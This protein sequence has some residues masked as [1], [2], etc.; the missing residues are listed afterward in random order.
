MA[1]VA[2]D[3][4]DPRWDPYFDKLEQREETIRDRAWAKL[5]RQIRWIYGFLV[6]FTVIVAFVFG[7][8]IDQ[9]ASRLDDQAAIR[10]EGRQQINEANRKLCVE[11]EKVKTQIRSVLIDG[12]RSV[13]AQPPSRDRTQRLAAYNATINRF[14][15]VH[16]PPQVVPPR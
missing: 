11:V 10:R 6:C 16:C 12:R 3:P 4:N 2:V 1:P 5:Q 7:R 13:E 15:P 9:N 14:A 8:Q